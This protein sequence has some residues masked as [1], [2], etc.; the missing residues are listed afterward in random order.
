MHDIGTTIYSHA[1][2]MIANTNLN[3]YNV[4]SPCFANGLSYIYH[5]FL[6]CGILLLYV[7]FLS[8][9]YLV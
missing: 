8:F 1:Q 3:P 9:V 2:G 4:M 7:G 5:V 6:I